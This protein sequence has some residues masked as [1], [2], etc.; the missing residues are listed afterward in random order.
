MTMNEIPVLYSFRR[1]P[2]AIRARMALKMSGIE[3]E[4]REVSLSDKPA[5]MLKSSPKG[6]VPVLVFAN[7]IV[8]DESLDI[9][10]WALEQ[11]DPDCWLPDNPAEQTENYHLIELCDSEFKQQLDGYKYADA[12]SGESMESYRTAAEKY[13][14]YIEK[15]LTDHR[16]LINERI[17]IA[18]VAIFPFIRQFAHVDK[19]W[20][21]QA[22][23]KKLQTWLDNFLHAALFSEV[24]MKYSC[25]TEDSKVQY[26]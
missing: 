6:T 20:F 24:M 12:K 3:V 9:M 7:G 4:L 26:F 16:Y 19:D 13:L 22:G 2:Y 10:I 17:N 8:I 5:K 15:K 11:S 18:D 14:R 23:Y 25:W 1:C 21:D